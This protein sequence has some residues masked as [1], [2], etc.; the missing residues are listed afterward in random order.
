MN[1][2]ST[3][4]LLIEISEQPVVAVQNVLDKRTSSKSISTK[5]TK[6]KKT[7]NNSNELKI[8]KQHEDLEARLEQRA[9]VLKATNWELRQEISRRAE[10]EQTVREERNR[11]RTLVETIP[12]GIMEFDI[13]G[14]ITFAN[15]ESHR[16][17]E[18]TDEESM[19]KCLWEILWPY[20]S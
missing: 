17:F 1:E 12:Y 20:S 15:A 9:V 6:Y 19:K 13:D 5:K 8:W 16:I 7:T 4:Q 18:F 10:V 3:A 14:I 2:K 11:Y